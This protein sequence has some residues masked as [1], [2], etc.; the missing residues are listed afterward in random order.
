MGI[1]GD[2]SKVNSQIHDLITVDFSGL[3]AKRLSAIAKFIG[4]NPVDTLS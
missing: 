3:E 1:C 4:P 2:Y